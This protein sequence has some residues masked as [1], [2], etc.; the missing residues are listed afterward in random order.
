MS[1]FFSKTLWEPYRKKT[2]AARGEL[3]IGRQCYVSPHW[4]CGGE[5]SV[6]RIT[7][8]DYYVALQ[9]NNSPVSHIDLSS[10]NVGHWRIVNLDV[11]HIDL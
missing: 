8:L 2:V 9:I 1:Q 6:R 4:V 7:S 10:E 3:L 5:T 11:S